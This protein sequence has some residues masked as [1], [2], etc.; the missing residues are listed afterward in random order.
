MAH[1]L[2]SWAKGLAAQTDAKLHHP[3]EVNLFSK[4]Y[5]FDVRNDT[6]SIRTVRERWV[7]VTRESRRESGTD[8]KYFGGGP[9]ERGSVLL[10]EPP[11]WK[12]PREEEEGYK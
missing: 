9:T 11:R 2:A 4:Q 6:F 5:A 10:M 8:S 7:N 1:A 3:E 12:S